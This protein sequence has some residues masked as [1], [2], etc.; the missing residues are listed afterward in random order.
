M[1]LARGL[2][3]QMYDICT[4]VSVF[5]M[6]RIKDDGEAETGSLSVLRCNECLISVQ[7]KG[8]RYLL[9]TDCCRLF[10]EALTAQVETVFADE[11]CLVGA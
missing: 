10:T 9:E 5:P 7:G 1:R 4:K 8:C 6:L 11:T 3:G 2:H